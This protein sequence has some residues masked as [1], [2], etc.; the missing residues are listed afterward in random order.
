MAPGSTT[1]RSRRRVVPGECDRV[2]GCQSAAERFPLRTVAGLVFIRDC[3]AV[4]AA[5]ARAVCT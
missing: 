1:A 2:G 4:L 3:E 5:M